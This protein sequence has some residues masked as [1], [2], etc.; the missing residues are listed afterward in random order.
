MPSGTVV[1]E[2]SATPE[3][4]WQVITDLERAPGWVPDLESVR[5]IDSGQMGVGARFA[6]VMRVQGRRV[7]VT[8]TI[9][10]F[11]PHERIAH[12]GEGGSVKIGG[13]TIIKETATGCTVTNNWSL[14][15]SGL[16]RFASPLAGAWTQ[17]NIQSSMDALK[18]MLEKES[19]PG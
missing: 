15:L 13:S 4:V 5:R 2:I 10:E 17:K 3:R 12:K 18:A 16:L 11:S 9:T 7:E 14:E 6:E 1:A 8:V 19:G